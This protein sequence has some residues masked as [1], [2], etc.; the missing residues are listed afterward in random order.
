MPDILQ[1]LRRAATQLAIRQA[2]SATAVVPMGLQRSVVRFLL[3]HARDIPLLRR[4]VLDNMRLALG[5]GIPAQA[6]SL[7]FHHLGWSLSNAL[8]TFH[9][10]VMATPVPE[11][12]KLDESV[13]LLDE[14]VA[15]GRGVVFATA[16]WSGHELVAA[17]VNRRHPMAMLVRQAPTAERMKRKMKWYKALGAEIILRPTGASTIKDAVAYLNVLKHGKLLGITPDLL[18]DAGQGIETSIFGRQA[19]LHGGAFALAFAAKAPM[20]RMSLRWESDTSVVAV[21][22]RAPL[23]LDGGDRDAAI[24]AGVQDWCR[25][26]EKKLAANPENWLFWL[27]KRWSR[28]LRTTPRAAGAE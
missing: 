17:I 12:V 18:A 27:D 4:R 10:G 13:R 1:Q 3:A 5:E 22:D 23:A 6:A 9:H 8:S 11:E 2:I 28:F 20:M 26:F 7:Y 25:W 14:A 24:R 15:E 16:H 19:Q 21:F